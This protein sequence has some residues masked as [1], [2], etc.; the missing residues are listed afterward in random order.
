MELINVSL[1]KVLNQKEGIKLSKE[2]SDSLFKSAEL[3]AA[4]SFFSP[5]IPLLILSAEEV[6]KSFGLSLEIF[7]GARSE[8]NRIIKNNKLNSTN[9]YLYN[10]T[11]KHK[12][13]NS[14]IHD[15]D[16]IYP[17][18]NIFKLI[19]KGALKKYLEFFTLPSG[20]REEIKLLLNDI[21]KFNEL[22]N[23]GFYVDAKDG[24]W[25]TPLSFSQRDYQEYKAKISLLV[26][27]F[28]PKIDIF[29]SIPNDILTNLVEAF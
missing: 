22:K 23:R 19:L 27:I 2:N 9:S 26:K 3:L 1:S 14:V 29:L 21:E 8:V 25:V 10:H 13:A 11:A 17:I 5:A 12:L 15:L 24:H 18:V 16:Q 28:S 6:I 4:H 7:L 20:Q